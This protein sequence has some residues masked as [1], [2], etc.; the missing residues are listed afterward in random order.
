MQVG[1]FYVLIY[2]VTLEIQYCQTQHFLFPSEPGIK[3]INEL[4][5]LGDY[6]YFLIYLTVFLEKIRLKK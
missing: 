5:C 4:C 1:F 2:L 3:G 6:V